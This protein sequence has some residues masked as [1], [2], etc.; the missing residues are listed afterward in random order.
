MFWVTSKKLFLTI[1][2]GSERGKRN[3]CHI[4]SVVIYEASEQYILSLVIYEVSEQY[5]IPL[6]VYTKSLKIY[7]V[8]SNIW[9]L[10][11]GN[12]VISGI[13]YIIFGLQTLLYNIIHTTWGIW[14][15]YNVITI[16]CHYYENREQTWFWNISTSGLKFKVCLHKT[17]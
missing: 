8:T 11:T 15:K 5:M 14:T 10:W 13:V 16:W 3:L 17:L 9:G 6:V 4:L 7:A 12:N 1:R 2:K